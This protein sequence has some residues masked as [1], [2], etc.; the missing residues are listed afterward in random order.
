MSDPITDAIIAD[1]LVAESGNARRGQRA[2]RFNAGAP[3]ICS[4]CGTP[5]KGPVCHSCGQDSDILQR[6]FWNHV[7]EILDGQFGIDGKLWRTLP[8]LMFRPG[9]ITRQYLSGVRARYVQPFRFYIFASFVF[10]FLFWGGAGGIGDF[11]RSEPVDLDPAALDRLESELADLAGDAPEE[12]AQVQ[13]V[14]DELRQGQA[15]SGPDPM[16]DAEATDSADGG[17]LS[18]GDMLSGPVLRDEMRTGV[19]QALLP[20]QTAD[21]ET[22]GELAPTP[23][24]AGVNVDFSG[25]TWLPYTVRERLVHQI[26]IIIDDPSRWFEAM[27]ASV[28]WLLILLL[29]VYALV[30]AIGQVWRRGFYYYDHL[31]VSLHF[32]SFLFVLLA[33]LMLL[34]P[35]IGGWGVPIFLVWSNFYLYKLHRVVYEHGRFMSFVRTVTL[36]FTYM[37]ILIFAFVLLMLVGLLAA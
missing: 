11:F 27:R 29:P 26:E 14:L 23:D 35:V 8:A 21:P 28:S 16:V 25:L 12:A 22:Q 36:D 3:G 17:A 1:S 34:S 20:E 24:E 19:R 2:G 37:I 32:H 31:I 30:I 9:H 4:N 10:L 6:P 13:R 15:A 33:I 5:L 7:L 18:I